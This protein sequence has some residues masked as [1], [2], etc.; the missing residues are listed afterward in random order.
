[1]DPHEPSD[2]TPSPGLPWMCY[3]VAVV[4]GDGGRVVHA[5]PG[6]MDAEAAVDSLVRVTRSYLERWGTPASSTTRLNPELGSHPRSSVGP[7]AGQSP[8]L[9]RDLP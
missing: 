2:H 4:V 8:F 6:V 5:R 3:A 1:M 7:R 9:H